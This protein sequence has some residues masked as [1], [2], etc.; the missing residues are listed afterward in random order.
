MFPIYSLPHSVRIAVALVMTIVSA[1]QGAQTMPDESRGSAA[2]D[3]R[4]DQTD[5]RFDVLEIQVEGNSVLS[6]L[7]I[8]RA[9]YPHLGPGKSIRDV[10]AARAQLEKAYHAAGYL[11]VT[12]DIPEQ[13][14]RGGL[15]RL[16]VNEARVERLQVTGSRYYSLGRIRATVT[17][18]AEGQ[19]PNFPEL[20]DQLAQVN[21]GA[22]R[23]IAPVLRA[24]RVPGHVEAE[25][26]VD[27]R[28]P[29]HGAVE[30][31]N[32]RSPNTSATRLGMNLRYDNLWQRD[33]SLGLA[34]QLSPQEPKETRVVSGT[35]VFPAGH[36]DRTLALY[37]LRSRSDVAAVGGVNVIGNG[38]IAGARWIALLRRAGDYSHSATLGIDHKRFKESV[39]LQGA[40]STTTPISYTPLLAQYGG[41]WVAENVE[42]QFNIGLHFAPRAALGNSST[43]FANKRF[44]AQAGYAF[45]RA[46]AQ[47]T[48][49]LRSKW[50]VHARFDAQLSADPLISNEQFAAGG[51]DSV[52]GYLESEVLADRGVRARLEVRTPR[53]HAEV[54]DQ[55]FFDQV[56]GAV[57][58]DAA[59]LRVIEP[60]PGQRDGFTL[61]SAGL[62]LRFRLFGVTQWLMDLAW[63]FKDTSNVRAGHTRYHVRVAYE[64]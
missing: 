11:T 9:V 40:D 38:D 7:A 29:L 46:D 62:G 5:A 12:V 14:V 39:T 1:A 51:V 18:L 22:D 53:W 13:E 30:L 21:R 58:Y 35:Y 52:R 42:T 64:F 57:F 3:K 49:V 2:S 4:A 54:K 20:Q 25:L 16:A 6:A 33:H 60:L 45:V 48:R 28:L 17:E 41:A 24:G 19:V 31:N 44:A 63:P 36:A 59:S 61:A 15:V 47:H 8:E 37:A 43:E 10:D 32:R 26:K 55:S 34:L 56:T 23:K 50:S 27:D